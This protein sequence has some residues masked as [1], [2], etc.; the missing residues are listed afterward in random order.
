MKKRL[1]AVILALLCVLS[2]TL[3]LSGCSGKNSN[4]PVTV[5]H[6]TLKQ[7]PEKVAVLS[8]NIADLVY[9][10]GYSTQICAISDSCTQEV[11][12]KYI[13]S[14]G[15]ETAPDVDGIT[16]SGAQYV[17]VDT[18]LSETVSDKL[19]SHG[20]EIIEFMKPNT[21]EQLST[22]YNAI[23]KFFG[24][25]PE[26]KET[27]T[28]AYNSVMSTLEQAEKA[29]E[30]STV[31]KLICY[32]YLDENNTLCSYNSSTCNGMVLDYVCA[33]NV[34]TNFTDSK[35]DESILRLS[36]P[37]FIFYDNE[38][39]LTYLNSD[40][41]LS[42]MN[43]LKNNN[44]YILPKENL[45]RMGTSMI[46]TQNFIISKLYPNSVSHSSSDESLAGA[47]GIT[48]SESSSYKNGDDKAEIKAIQQRLIDLGYLTLDSGDSA[49]T[50]FG[51]KSEEAVKNFQ[52]ANGL[53]ATGVADYK[54]LVALFDAATLSVSGQP[55]KPGIDSTKPETT[56][57]ATDTNV[58]SGYDIDLSSEKSYQA[59]DDDPDIAVMQQR[60]IDLGYLTLDSGDSATEYFGGMSEEAVK[61]FQSENGLDATGVADYE[62]LKL[63]FSENAH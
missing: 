43:A 7:K 46:E 17:L 10:M 12:T 56:K 13:E 23:G 31:V 41:S 15:S 24:G 33:T 48:L 1:L 40:N 32:L 58:V 11:L 36:N 26:G 42:T 61:D 21:Q 53:D 29:V 62:T 6:T 9:Y 49:T 51:G 38:S 18:P 39:V 5:G 14:V 25:Y 59:G 52:T 19:K 30:G 45:E 28:T 3:C 37:D 22:L 20:I 35:V 34:A 47:Y 8:D 50:Y 27:G 63:L 54:T 60:L 55:V 16:R 44:T 4:F 2:M 57:P